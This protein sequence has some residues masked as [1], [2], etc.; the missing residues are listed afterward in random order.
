MAT[1]DHIPVDVP[2]REKTVLF[3]KHEWLNERQLIA[4][5]GAGKNVFDL[6]D[7]AGLIPEPD[8]A[9][10]RETKLWSADL[11]FRLLQAMPILAQIYAK[12]S[13]KKSSTS[14]HPVDANSGATGV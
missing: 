8:F 1:E 11:A 13:Q 2:T 9:L 6:L 10:N 14:S 4:Y 12:F 3:P 7:K 5:L